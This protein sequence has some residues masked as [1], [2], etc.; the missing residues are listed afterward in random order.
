MRRTVSLLGSPP[1]PERADASR[2]RELLLCTARRLVRDVGVAGL[3]MDAL[4]AE[5]GL[6]KGTVFRRFGSRAGLFAA[7]LDEYERD[8]QAA[9]LSGPPPLGPGAEPVARLVAFGHERLRFLA[10]RGYLLREADA[11][12]TRGANAPAAFAR[13][14]VRVLLQA[15]GVGG[16]VEVLAFNLLAALEAPLDFHVERQLGAVPPLSPQRLAAGWS[17]LVARVVGPARA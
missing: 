8:F 12:L 7:L 15:A 2:N 16:D 4:A 11:H 5:A 13:L 17:D 1:P 9:C 14:H 3:S 10:D 6:G